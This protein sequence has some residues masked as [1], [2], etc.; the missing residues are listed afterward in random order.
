VLDL[1]RFKTALGSNHEDKIRSS[2]VV[3]SFTGPPGFDLS[4]LDAFEQGS[5]EQEAACAEI[6]KDLNK[7]RNRAPAKLHE[8]RCRSQYVELTHDGTDWTRPSDVEK[9]AVHDMLLEA[10]NRYRGITLFILPKCAGAIGCMED[11]G[12]LE[13]LRDFANTYPPPEGDLK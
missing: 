4:R 2:Q 9:G 1:K 11:L 8:L 3:F 12:L 10:G 7:I 5:P 13:T 6:L